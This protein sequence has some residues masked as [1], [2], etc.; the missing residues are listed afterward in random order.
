VLAAL[1]EEEPMTAG[2]V[3][4]KS[5]LARGVVSS[6]LS[7]LTR[8]GEVQKAAR[9]YRLAQ[10]TAPPAPLA[11]PPAPLAPS[12]P[13]ASEPSAVPATDSSETP[14]DATAKSTADPGTETPAS[15]PVAAE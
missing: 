4:E 6:T 15:A 14:P 12:A 10:A 11:A 3:A 8:S 1:A 5:G 13:A 7:R 2:E 9:G